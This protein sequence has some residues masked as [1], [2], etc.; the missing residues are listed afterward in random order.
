M[1]SRLFWRY[2]WRFNLMYL[3]I[4]ASA[5][6][7]G[8]GWPALKGVFASLAKQPKAW[9]KRRQI[10]KSRRASLDYIDS[11]IHKGPLPNQTGLIK[12]VSIFKKRAS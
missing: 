1:P 10:Q 5:V 3:L 7:H 9:K 11:I 2:V 4:F 8:N 6:R 12:F